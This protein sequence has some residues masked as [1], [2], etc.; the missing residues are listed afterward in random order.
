MMRQLTSRRVVVRLILLVIVT[1]LVFI[2]YVWLIDV[3]S[4]DDNKD[5]DIG[6]A[7]TPLP[8]VEF[9][10][11]D[12]NNSKV[13]AFTDHE[14]AFS[15]Q[16]LMDEFGDRWQFSWI[17]RRI[18]RMW[19]EISRA[20][21]HVTDA[22]CSQW[23]RPRLRIM[24]IPGVLTLTNFARPQS[25]RRGG[26]LGELVQWSDL[27]AACYAL[28]HSLAPRLRITSTAGELLSEVDEKPVNASTG[29]DD[30]D[31]VDVIFADLVAVRALPPEILQAYRYKLRVL[32]VFGTEAIYNDDAYVKSHPQLE[33]KAGWGRLGLRLKQF[34][35]LYPHTPDNSFLGFI[36]PREKL[37]NVTEKEN[38][39]L[40]IGKERR[41]LLGKET[42][43]KTVLKYMPLKA[44]MR[45]VNMPG[46]P[47][48][49][50]TFLGVVSSQEYQS[51]IV[52]AKLCIGL[53]DPVE[54]PSAIEA[55]ACGCVFLNPRRKGEDVKFQGK[56]TSRQVTSQ[57]PY[58]ENFI[59]PPHAYTVN[60]GDVNA[61][62][63]VLDNITHTTH[64]VQPFIPH[65]F[66]AAGFVERLHSYL[67]HQR[68]CPHD[69]MSG[70]YDTWP[71]VS[72]LVVRL[73]ALNESCTRTCH[74][75]GFVCEPEYFGLLNNASFVEKAAG[76]TCGVV[77]RVAEPFAP[78]LHLP[79]TA[80]HLDAAA[81]DKCWLQSRRELFSCAESVNAFRVCPCRRYRRHQIALV[82]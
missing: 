22:R 63:A 21:R 64:V 65:E 58:F 57:V 82:P 75:A 12:N 42:M 10:S 34:Y 2:V 33:Y 45:E 14:D 55:L 24:F 81:A 69:K 71:P 77:K 20:G 50:I 35:T 46:L 37:I 43:L 80:I 59:G 31:F 17:K 60:Y 51:I 27:I 11:Q 68:F 8:S 72:E 61:L 62:S 41:Y 36:V 53:G 56:P 76:A 4:V 3:E 29:C 38:Y 67:S 19:P 9:N 7:R 44:T 70:N 48:G 66:T 39:A 54:S 32:D 13:D 6:V 1:K 73:S 18:M 30:K 25:I 79:A 23:K 28:C 78:A 15:I 49:A 47:S 40:I 52:N 5:D 26:P 16:H 74:V